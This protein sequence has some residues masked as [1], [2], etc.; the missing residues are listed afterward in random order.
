MENEQNVAPGEGLIYGL[1]DRPPLKDTIFAALQHLLA[2]FVALAGVF[3][4]ILFECEY[5]RKEIAIR[6][7]LGA[8]AGGILWR[9][10]LQY[11]GW[12][13]ICFV[14]SVPVAV[15]FGSS[16]L[17]N[18]AYRTDFP[19]LV[20][21]LVLLAIGALVAGIVTCQSWHVASEK[22]LENLKAE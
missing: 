22:P 8:T 15:Y 1:N 19:V 2:I 17:E 5:R 6:K 14:L 11:L 16:W 13:A 10:N 7:A 21:P 4:L 3:S 9:L 20:F 12:V 18:F